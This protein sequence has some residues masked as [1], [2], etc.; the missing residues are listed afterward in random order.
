[1]QNNYSV[2]TIS[3]RKLQEQKQFLKGEALAKRPVTIS[4]KEQQT[5]NDIKDAIS[6]VIRVTFKVHE[7]ESKKN[8]STSV[9]FPTAKQL[10]SQFDQVDQLKGKFTPA[11]ATS[12]VMNRYTFKNTLKDLDGD[13][14]KLR[15]EIE[16]NFEQLFTIFEQDEVKSCLDGYFEENPA[17][18]DLD[19]K[20]GSG[21]AGI[22]DYFEQC[23]YHENVSEEAM[24]SIISA[25]YNVYGLNNGGYLDSL[26]MVSQVV[27]VL[28]GLN[29]SPKDQLVV[30]EKCY[31]NCPDAENFL[32]CLVLFSMNIS[33]TMRL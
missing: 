27:Q 24:D 26:T 25:T 31:A 2:L 30:L 11:M 8:Q 20:H 18:I 23:V 17:G 28:G 19:E 21:F 22:A 3:Q 10:P 9:V 16:E 33:K 5:V 12:L 4:Y 7:L 32:A 14:N 6:N 29:L 13:L 15:K 1:M